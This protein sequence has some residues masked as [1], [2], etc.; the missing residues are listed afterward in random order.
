[1]RRLRISGLTREEERLQLRQEMR[2]PVV[3]RNHGNKRVQ[4]EREQVQ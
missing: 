2:F 4:V 3:G 1:M